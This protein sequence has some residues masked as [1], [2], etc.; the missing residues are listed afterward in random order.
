MRPADRGERVV[1][2]RALNELDWPADLVGFR[3]LGAAVCSY[4]GH[5]MVMMWGRHGGL[6]WCPGFDLEPPGRNL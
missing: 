5:V 6:M 2:R 4:C 1:V 3:A